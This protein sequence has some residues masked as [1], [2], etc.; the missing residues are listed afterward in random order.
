MTPRLRLGQDEHEAFLVHA[1]IKVDRYAFT[2]VTFSHQSIAAPPGVHGMLPRLQDS[3][4]SGSACAQVSHDKFF[5]TAPVAA[6]AVT[7]TAKGIA[8][9]FLLLG[10]AAGQVYL[11]PC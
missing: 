1:I 9:K 6:M 10:T 2:V 3:L 7:S 11:Q 8:P 5:W 4:A